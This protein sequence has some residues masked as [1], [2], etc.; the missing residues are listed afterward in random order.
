MR[1]ATIQDQ[2]QR[3]D[4]SSTACQALEDFGA[5]CAPSGDLPPHACRQDDERQWMNAAIQQQDRKGRES[6][7]DSVNRAITIRESDKPEDEGYWYRQCE[8][9]AN[10]GNG[11]REF[12]QRRRAREGV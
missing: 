10:V 5:E 2:Q 4:R 3:H 6:G 7:K 8:E 1:Q 11:R 9:H 12:E